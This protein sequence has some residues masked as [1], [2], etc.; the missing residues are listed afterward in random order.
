MAER[1]SYR[2]D[3]M[4]WI[5]RER[6]VSIIRAGSADQAAQDLETLVDAGLT[7]IEVSLTTPGRRT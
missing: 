4:Q 1:R 7:V 6:V 2:W 5:A 3:L